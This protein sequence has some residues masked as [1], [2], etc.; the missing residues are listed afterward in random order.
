MTTP[1]A[2]ACQSCG[3]SIS[4][5]LYCQ[6]CTTEDGALQPFDERFERMLQWSLRRNPALSREEAERQTRAY[7]RTMPAWRDHPRLRET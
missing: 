6:Y 1:S 3:M 2:H 5:G 7:M 4:S